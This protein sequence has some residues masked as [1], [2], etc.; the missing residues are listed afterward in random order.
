MATGTSA[1]SEATAAKESQGSRPMAQDTG[2]K[3]TEP[4]PPT[5]AP[6]SSARVL[7]G[8]SSS[9]PA[10]NS[11][12]CDATS[13]LCWSLAVWTQAVKMDTGSNTMTMRSST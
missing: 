9:T 13:A 4:R 5:N 1:G 6:V 10:T 12:R 8:D 2:H 11:G 3:S 7:Q